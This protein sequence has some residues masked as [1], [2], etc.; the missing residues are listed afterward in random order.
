MNIDSI[1]KRVSTR[2]GHKIIAAVG[3]VV[4]IALLA[5]GAYYTSSQEKSILE[6]NERTM[7]A[8]TN[9]VIQ[10]LQTMMLA[11]YAD[12][13]RNFADRLEE[14]P[15][16]VEFRILRIDGSQAFLDNQTIDNV[17]TR[18]GDE[19]FL[20]R[21]TEEVNLVLSSDHPELKKAIQSQ[22]IIPYYETSSDGVRHLTFLAPIENQKDCYKCHGRSNPVRGVLKLT[23]S[24]AAVQT[25]IKSTMIRS[26]IVIAAAITGIILLTGLL[27]RHTVV[28]PIHSVTRAM[29]RAADGDLTQQIPVI[30][31]DELSQMADSF[32]HMTKQLLQTYTGL[33]NE[34]DKLSTIIL[35]A[36]E[37]IVV[38]DYSG[39]VVLINPAAET[40][41][42]KSTEQIIEEGFVNI[43]D[44]PEGLQALL[45]RSPE[46]KEPETVR[47]NEFV[48]SIH[49]ATIRSPQ[50]N[51]IGSAALLRDI[52]EEKR[53]EE[54]LRRLSTTDGLTGLYNRRHLDETLAVEVER[55]RRYNNPLSIL[56]FD[57]DHFKRFNDDYG[58]DQGDRVLRALALAMQDLLRKV[59]V[60]CRYGGEEF[61]AILPGTA[62]AGAQI[63]AE[64][65][66][67]IIEEMEVDGLH[68]TISI[69]V[70]ALPEIAVDDANSF[71]EA[72][73]QALYA[74]KRAGRNQVVAAHKA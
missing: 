68:V 22:E 64:R 58:H 27:I 36:R 55:S 18:R 2:I 35:S 59:D 14:V 61:L 29:V 63:V 6:Q 43:L 33:Q 52:T 9:S 17:N 73:D 10:G 20:P 40:L 71:I 19:E 37:G 44:D 30:G 12:I 23:T 47:Y 24:L 53:L 8:L 28:S 41:L 45:D 65:L 31:N 26:M 1:T 42:G 38:T 49:A 56:M 66:R 74:A 48:L 54:R 51:P 39:N 21:E 50:G 15:D 16:V 34:Q 67:S 13:A 5:L 62:L 11:G 69:G 32:N 7:R 46:I 57:V 72:A 60:P 25:N 70:A 3:L 4:T